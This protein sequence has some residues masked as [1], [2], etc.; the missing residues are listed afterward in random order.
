M[1]MKKQCTA[2]K[3]LLWAGGF[4]VLFLTGCE[5]FDG[6]ENTNDNGPKTG[7]V[8]DIDGNEYQTVK[9][10][11]HMWMTENLRT[12]RYR[13]GTPITNGLNAED[14]A[15]AS[16]GAYTVYPHQEVEGINSDEEMVNAYGLLYNWEAINDAR[17]LCPAGWRIP[18]CD[19][20]SDL[21]EFVEDFVD[22]EPQVGGVG[23]ALK[24]ARQVGHPWGGMH[25]TD[26]H[27]RWNA[28]LNH[29]GWDEFGYSAYASGFRNHEGTFRDLGYVA[30]W[31]STTEQSTTE[32]YVRHI[33]NW[34][35]FMIRRPADKRSGLSVRCIRDAK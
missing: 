1:R 6:D 18:E 23:N 28:S 22:K 17:G 10:W 33:W 7:T 35:N 14:W 11:E 31:W 9:L 32:V 3:A 5:L 19:E 12:T 15:I 2:G 8:S 30:V 21:R 4:F 34:E 13:D 20:W 29:Y 26:V 27:P 25:D 24:A 16:E